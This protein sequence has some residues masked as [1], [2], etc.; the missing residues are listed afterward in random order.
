MK[1]SN[2]GKELKESAKFCGYCGQRVKIGKKKL[3]T[4]ILSIVLIVSLCILI[5]LLI[6]KKNIK[7]KILNLKYNN[8]N[9]YT[10]YNEF[11]EEVNSIN[12]G[13]QVF[14]DDSTTDKE[15]QI[16]ENNLKSIDGIGTVEYISKDKTYFEMA[17]KL[18]D[19]RYLMNDIDYNT[20]HSSYKITVSDLNATNEIYNKIITLNN[21]KNVRNDYEKLNL[22]IKAKN[23][24]NLYFALIIILISLFI[25]SNIIGLLFTRKKLKGDGR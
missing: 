11:I 14:I 6:N 20:F 4:R 15:K 7:F 25:V 18:G 2:C 9:T 22:Y 3:Y 17:D 21:V 5:I 13:M 23:K 8:L 12:S 10:N 1:C 16:I 24:V 19:N